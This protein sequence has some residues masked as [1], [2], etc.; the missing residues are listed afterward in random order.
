MGFLSFAVPFLAAAFLIA[1]DLMNRGHAFPKV[2]LFLASATA[3]PAAAH[4]AAGMTARPLFTA[5]L[6]H[7]EFHGGLVFLTIPDCLALIAS[8]IMVARFLAWAL[9]PLRKGGSD[10]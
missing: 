9:A 6:F 7:F 8:T 5:P 10:D 1:G 2:D 4:A 3:T